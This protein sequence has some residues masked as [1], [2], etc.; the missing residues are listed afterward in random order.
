MLTQMRF[1]YKRDSQQIC[2]Y[3]NTL[4]ML[5]TNENKVN[6]VYFGGQSITR[7]C[8]AESQALVLIPFLGVL[9]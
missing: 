1:M 2:Y 9:G 5:S 3:Y 4:K 6:P 7:L 8:C